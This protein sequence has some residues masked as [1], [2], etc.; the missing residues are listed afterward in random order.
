MSRIFPEDVLP[1]KSPQEIWGWFEEVDYPGPDTPWDEYPPVGPYTS[2]DLEFLITS[3][4]NED[5][6]EWT[7]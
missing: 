7:D 2:E 3:Q 1:L 4:L 6:G 5:R